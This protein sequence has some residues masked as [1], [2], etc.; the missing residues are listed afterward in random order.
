VFSFGCSPG[1]GGFFVF[2]CVSDGSGVV[3]R[4][5]FVWGVCLSSSVVFFLFLGL[6]GF[7]GAGSLWLCF[8]FCLFFFFFFF[9]F[10]FLFFFFFCGVGFLL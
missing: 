3:V 8:V 2:F 10:F 1:G 5:V 7:G 4:R 6:G 9:F